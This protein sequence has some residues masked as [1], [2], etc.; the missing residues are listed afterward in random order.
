[1]PL[2]VDDRT[3]HVGDGT[4]GYS[5]DQEARIERGVGVIEKLWWKARNTTFMDVR[6]LP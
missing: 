2:E 1:M 3:S 4:A 6:A 5:D